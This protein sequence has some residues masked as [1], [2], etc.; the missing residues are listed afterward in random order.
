MELYERCPYCGNRTQGLTKDELPVEGEESKEES[1]E[2]TVPVIQTNERKSSTFTSRV[3]IEELDNL[4]LKVNT[5]S[6]K[7]KKK[8]RSRKRK[9]CF[10]NVLIAAS[11]GNDG[12]VMAK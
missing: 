3:Q 6:A 2:E 7:K 11:R 1:V 5:N 8:R 12:C 9:I 10:S 4:S